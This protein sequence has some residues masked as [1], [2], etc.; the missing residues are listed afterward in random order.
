MSGMKDAVADGLDHFGDQAAKAA[1]KG[2]KQ[3]LAAIA[4]AAL[5]KA[6]AA[7]MRSTGET[8][9]EVLAQIKPTRKLDLSLDRDSATETKNEKRKPSLLPPAKE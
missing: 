6:V 4:A 1:R 9:D 2:G 7:R 3:G 8:V 5:L